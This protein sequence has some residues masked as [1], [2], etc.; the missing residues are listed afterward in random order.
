MR[1]ILW[2]GC[3]TWPLRV[4]ERRL[5]VFENE[6]LR[7]ILRHRRAEH[8]SCTELRRQC[9]LNEIRSIRLQDLLRWF[10]NVARCEEG[11]MIRDL[12]VAKS[13]LLRGKEPVDSRNYWLPFSRRTLQYHPTKLFAVLADES[14]TGWQYTKIA[15]ERSGTR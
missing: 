8:I 7:R 12:L 6:C 2:Y 15:Q 3:D 5:E 4:A 11:E 14:E 9:Q 13:L 10:G 1:F